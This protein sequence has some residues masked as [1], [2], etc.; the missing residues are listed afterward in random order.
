M[1]RPWATTIALAISTGSIAGIGAIDVPRASAQGAAPDAASVLIEGKGWG[2]GVGLAQD[3][4][5]WMGVDGADTNRILST[6]YPSTAIGTRSGSVRVPVLLS[7]ARSAVLAFPGGGEIRQR[8]AGAQGAGFPLVVPPGGRVA[9]SNDGTNY[10]AE[11]LAPD[12]GGA[13]RPR[14]ALAASSQP[15]SGP[16]GAAQAQAPSPTVPA[17]LAGDGATSTTS[18]TLVP[19]PTPRTLVPRTT[20]PSTTGRTVRPRGP[21]PAPTVVA[22]PTTSRAVLEQRTS[23]GPLEAV[24][25]GGDAIVVEAR[26]RRYRGRIEA[27]TAPGGLRLVNELDVE[28]YLRGMGEVRDPSWPAA[29]LRAQAIAART[30]A[31]RAMAKVGEIC[32]DDRC[33]VYLGAQVEYAE[34]DRAVADTAGQVLL[35]DGDLATAVYSANAGGY[36][37]T[38][39]EGFGTLAS[40]RPYLQANR[41]STRD[42]MPWKVQA[43]VAEMGRRLGYPGTLERVT[44]MHTGPSGRVLEV[45]LE[46]PAGTKNVPGVTA[47]NRLGLKSSLFTLRDARS[48]PVPGVDGLGAEG[49]SGLADDPGELGDL[50][51][52]SFGLQE[53]S[54]GVF[55]R[56]DVDGVLQ[57]L[58]DE[59]PKGFSDPSEAIPSEEPAA[60]ATSDPVNEVFDRWTW[61]AT[62]QVL[63]IMAMLI[64]LLERRF[65]L[66]ALIRRRRWTPPASRQPD[67]TI[68]VGGTGAEGDDEPVAGGATA[69]S[70]AVPVGTEVGILGAASGLRH[71][72]SVG[73]TPELRKLEPPLPPR[74]RGGPGP[75]SRPESTGGT[76]GLTAV[77]RPGGRSFRA[78][79]IGSATARFRDLAGSDPAGPG[80][81]TAASP[82][83]P[84]FEAPLDEPDPDED[85]GGRKGRKA[86]EARLRGPRVGEPLPQGLR[87][88]LLRLSET[89]RNRRS[90]GAKFG[91]GLGKGRS[92]PKRSG[93]RF[94]AGCNRQP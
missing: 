19:R 37:A 84:S 11:L 40:A 28:T 47:A 50:L 64:A 91:A 88:S 39:Q 68:T 42:P 23:P 76:G 62:L 24:G 14:L 1:R 55:G 80:G 29:S 31:L 17:D 10:R 81:A 63:V 90:S 52:G 27:T 36:T 15:A 3:G 46:G 51:D 92:G 73:G 13:P 30:Y 26:S 16:A 79:P 75:A 48:G 58:P 9:L 34:M 72:G 94:G 44:V 22:P 35:F 6:F 93:R 77:P 53:R 41:Y 32:E 12:G 82:R 86:K 66:G 89:R 5:R 60:P 83:V 59:V 2:H 4:A 54:E 69:T 78:G 20:V 56:I 87:G 61:S 85:V 38:P 7:S 49:D 43:S 65:L 74:L 71:M 8:V 45:A 70:A 67:G 57:R 18:R 25:A 33:Q 21:V